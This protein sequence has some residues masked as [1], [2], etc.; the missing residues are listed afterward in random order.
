M[1]KFVLYLANR[2]SA[3]T[4]DVSG[5]CTGG[6]IADVQTNN[7][8]DTDQINDKFALGGRTLPGFVTSC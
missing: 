2:R 5:D 6:N 3:A 1:L 7:I 8:N 4:N